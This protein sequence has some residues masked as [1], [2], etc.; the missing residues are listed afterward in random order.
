MKTKQEKSKTSTTLDVTPQGLLI[1]PTKTVALRVF[2][3]ELI[4]KLV[5][6]DKL[7]PGER[8]AIIAKWENETSDF[9]NR[10]FDPPTT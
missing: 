6:E 7:L 2:Q 4:E 5:A 10:N 9:L 8:N 3:D 1:H